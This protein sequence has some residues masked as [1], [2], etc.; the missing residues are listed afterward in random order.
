MMNNAMQLLPTVRTVAAPHGPL[1]DVITFDF[2]LQLSKLLKSQ[3][4]VNQDKLL[5]DMHNLTKS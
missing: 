4:I 5:I 2:V 3:T 1:C